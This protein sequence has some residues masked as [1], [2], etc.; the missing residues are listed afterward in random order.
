[1]R[2]NGVRQAPRVVDLAGA[3]F[4][5][6]AL[7][8]TEKAASC[9]TPGS[10]GSTYGSNPLAMSVG[11]AVLDVMLEK[12]FLLHV[13]AMGALLHNKL[14]QL[15]EAYPHIVTEVRGYG[16]M[17]GL[18]TAVSNYMLADALREAGLLT[19]PAAGDSIIRILPPLILT[20]L[21]VEEAIA[22]FTGVFERG[23]S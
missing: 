3:G 9:M 21:Q 12:D 11:N 18:K 8:A 15:V 20:P 17:L 22:I 5:L 14:S 16:L 1:M 10:H 2:G 7:L 4:P 6:A 19:A 23:V 13:R